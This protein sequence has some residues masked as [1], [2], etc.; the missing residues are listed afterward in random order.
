MR[1]LEKTFYGFKRSVMPGDTVSLEY[2]DPDGK[3]TIVERHVVTRPWSFDGGIVFEV[4]P[5][6]F[7]GNVVDGMG[8]VF[9]D[10]DGK[11][12]DDE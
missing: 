9:V 1:I 4:E 8:G 10:T 6:E 7:D 2:T 3:M 5:G 12:F 11:G